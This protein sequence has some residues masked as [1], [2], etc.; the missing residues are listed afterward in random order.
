MLASADRQLRYKSNETLT[1]GSENGN[2]AA[3][4]G[5]QIRLRGDRRVRIRPDGLPGRC[6]SS[7]TDDRRTMV[8]ILNIYLKLH[9]SAQRN[10][11]SDVIKHPRQKIKVRYLIPG[12]NLSVDSFLASWETWSSKGPLPYICQDRNHP[13]TAVD[14]A[15]RYR[16]CTLFALASQAFTSAANKSR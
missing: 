6:L 5:A 9:F 1:E 13:S 10:E 14:H 3:T 8:L 4:S 16:G 7:Q 2:A 11:T 12:I 15:Q